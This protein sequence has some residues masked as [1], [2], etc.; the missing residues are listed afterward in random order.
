MVQFG[1][2]GSA[3]KTEVKMGPKKTLKEASQE[4]RET[5]QSHCQRNL[6]I[7]KNSAVQGYPEEKDEEGELTEWGS[8]E[9]KLYIFPS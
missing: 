5:A 8:I 7:E 6:F 1:S 9:S 2:V 3:G 4:N